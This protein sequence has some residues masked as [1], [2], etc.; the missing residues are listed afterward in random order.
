MICLNGPYDISL[1]NNMTL[2]GGYCSFEK[3]ELFYDQ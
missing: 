1:E 2:L 3:R